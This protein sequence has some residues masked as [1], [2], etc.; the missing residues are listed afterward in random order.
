MG[1][2]R[3]RARQDLRQ[4]CQKRPSKGRIPLDG[5]IG[6]PPRHHRRSPI[7][8]GISCSFPMRLQAPLPPIEASRYTN[9]VTLKP[10][11]P[12]T[13]HRARHRPFCG[14]EP[15]AN[16][17]RTHRVASHVRDHL[18][19]RRGQNHAD[20][21]AAAVFRQHPDR[22]LGQGKGKLE[23]RRLRLDGHRE[24]ARHLRHLLRAAVR[25]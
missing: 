11:R 16:A 3:S 6:A 23:A 7:M 12:A 13:R 15:H 20:R 24:G 1:R 9:L 5:T 10:H 18:A 17:G 19:P 22:R 4:H 25:A 14:K 8:T 2:R 21:E